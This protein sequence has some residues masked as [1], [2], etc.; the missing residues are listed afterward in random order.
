[1]VDKGLVAID[2]KYEGEDP[3]NP[4][5][6]HNWMAMFDFRLKTGYFKPFATY[7]LDSSTWWNASI[8]GYLLAKNKKELGTSPSWRDGEYSSQRLLIEGYVQKI[9]SM[10][11]TLGINVIVT[12]HLDEIY[13]MRMVG[14]QREKVFEKY[15]Y[16]TVG[17]SRVFLPAMFDAVIVSCKEKKGGKN[18]YFYR[19]NESGEYLARIRTTRVDKL[20][21]KE[22]QA[23]ANL[24]KKC[25]YSG[26]SKPSLLEYIASQEREAQEKE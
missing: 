17:K 22:P 26:A 14:N 4:R 25:G 3:D 19:V 21:D 9:L 18:E 1:M 11:S 20:R 15:R 12:G 2:A 16:L 23:I 8:M 6:F 24:M 10:S 13:T 7:V 5:A